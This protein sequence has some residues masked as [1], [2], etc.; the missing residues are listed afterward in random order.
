[1]IEKIEV[2]IDEVKNKI[3]EFYKPDLWHFVCL[4][5]NDIEGTCK[6]QWIFSKYEE[7]E[8][9]TVFECDVAFNATVPTITDIIPSAIMSEMEIV[10]LFGLK[11]QTIK[12]GL[13]LDETSQQTPLK[14]K[15]GN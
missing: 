14:E 8:N 3:K 5:A 9:F 6:L 2:N 11:I 13:Y 7:K 1:M 12:K 10:D 4:N 15:N